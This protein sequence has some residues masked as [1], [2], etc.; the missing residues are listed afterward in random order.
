MG[1]RRP[2]VLEI[3]ATRLVEATVGA[4]GQEDL[5]SPDV[6]QTSNDLNWI[7]MYYIM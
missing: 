2:H 5:T 1:F 3:E 6:E 4:R 7:I